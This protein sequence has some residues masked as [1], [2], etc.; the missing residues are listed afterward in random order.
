MSS[1]ENKKFLLL[2]DPSGLKSLQAAYFTHNN[3]NAENSWG[4]KTVDAHIG[5]AQYLSTCGC[6]AVVPTRLDAY[7]GGSFGNCTFDLYSCQTVE[8]KLAYGMRTLSTTIGDI[9]EA[10]RRA[11]QDQWFF[12]EV[13]RVVLR[14]DLKTSIQMRIGPD[15]YREIPLQGTIEERADP[16]NYE[17][18][19]HP[20]LEREDLC[21]IAS[22]ILLNGPAARARQQVIRSS[23][24]KV[25]PRPCKRR[26]S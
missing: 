5:Q 1:I 4:P 21:A 11:L 7:K 2:W 12:Y 14:L 16:L 18:G 13:N 19:I 9:S 6:A 8:I 15:Q 26:F 23:G 20:I 17:I 25:N 3:P 10:V 24:Q 22:R